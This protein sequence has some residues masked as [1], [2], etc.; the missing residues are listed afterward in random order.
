MTMLFLGL[1]GLCNLLN[2]SG[3]C[4]SFLHFRVTNLTEYK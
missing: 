1:V 2:C 3:L 4:V